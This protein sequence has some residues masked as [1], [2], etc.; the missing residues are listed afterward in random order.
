[1]VKNRC[2]HYHLPGVSFAHFHWPIAITDGQKM[3][4]TTT[5]GST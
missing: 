4:K 1:M 5:E 3:K 2:D